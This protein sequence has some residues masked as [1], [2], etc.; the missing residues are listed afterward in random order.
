MLSGDAVLNTNNVTSEAE[1]IKSEVQLRKLHLIS[2]NAMVG[3]IATAAAASL[4]VVTIGASRPEWWSVVW[5]LV[6]MLVSVLR[7]EMA[8]RFV[9]E[10]SRKS[11]GPLLW[12]RRY[13]LLIAVLGIWW[14]IGA[15]AFSWNGS[16]EER[17]LAALVVAA[18]AAGSISTL[19]PLIK[20]YRLYTAPMVVSVALVSFLNA[21]DVFDWFFGVVAL[22]YLYGISR[23]ASYLSE[24]LSGSIALAI[25]ER[26]LAH[27]L[28]FAN[29]VYQAIGDAVLITDSGGGDTGLQ[30]GVRES[31]WLRQRTDYRQKLARAGLRP[32][33]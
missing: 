6:I 12:E 28:R 31:Q 23:S 1:D 9:Q 14:A 16:H 29:L 2:E 15:I 18:M 21:T 25:S 32:A 30:Q 17:Y 19:A 33:R 7:L 20:L 13:V 4:L 5:W 11:A 10:E 24:T 3:L 26:N 22:V 8:R 27:E